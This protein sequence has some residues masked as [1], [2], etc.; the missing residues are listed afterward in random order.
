MHQLPASLTLLVATVVVAGCSNAMPPPSASKAD[1]ARSSQTDAAQTMCENALGAGKVVSAGPM[2][3]V[4]DLRSMRQGPGFQPAK[5]AFP[6]SAKDDAAAFCWT[7][8]AA[9]LYDSF[10]VTA[11]GQ[12][13][14]LVSVGGMTTPP[15]GPP[16]VP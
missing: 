2:T 8:G 14:K 4:G 9:D 15:S 16:V 11:D 3:T 1:R 10:G 12:R 5:D 6:G 7:K 13:V